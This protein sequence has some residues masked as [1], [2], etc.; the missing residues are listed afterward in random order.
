[1]IFVIVSC[2]RESFLHFWGAATERNFVTFSYFG[3]YSTLGVS[4]GLQRE[5]GVPTQARSALRPSRVNFAGNFLFFLHRFWREI[6]VNFSLAHPNPGKRSTENFTKIS[7]Q[8][9]RHLWQRK[10]EK[11][12]ASALLQGSC[13]EQERRR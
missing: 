13:S 5:S 1:M 11:T 10:M 3:G 4:L 7:R 2:Q 12:F 9:S 6:L 8:I